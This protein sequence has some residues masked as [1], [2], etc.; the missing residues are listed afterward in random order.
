M[1]VHAIVL[2]AGKGTR[3]RSDL[4]KVL[5]LAAGRPLLGWVL[6]SVAGSSPDRTVVVVGHAAADVEAILPDDVD[7]ALQEPQRG[8][9][10]AV[11]VAL[12]HLG[13]LPADD[14]VLVG[15]GD[16][17]L[18]APDTYRRLIDEVG[19]A[20]AAVLTVDPGP[21]GFGRIV[22]SGHGA[23]AAIVEE[24]DASPDEM[25]LT[26][27]NAGIYA[28]RAG[29]LVEG[30]TRIDDRNAQGELYLT[31]VIGALSSKGIRVMGVRAHPDEVVGVN[32]HEELAAVQA[33]LR[34]R[35]NSALMASG[36]WMLDPERTYVDVGVTVAP[37]ARLH[38]GT[39]LTGLTSVDEDA[40]IGPDTYVEDSRVG[41]GARVWYSVLRG[42]VVGPEAEVGPY[43]SLRPGAV[44]E[45]RAKAGTFVEMKETVVGEGAKVPHLSYLGDASVGRGANVGAGTITCN[46]DGVDKHRTEIGEEAFIGSD[47]MLVAP[48]TI[49]A[50]AVTGAGSVITEDV[51]EGAL[52]VERSPQK[53]V[54]GYAERR[55]LRRRAR[56]ADTTDCETTD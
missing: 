36:V 25:E 14:T 15:Y 56:D 48:V 51:P 32:T 30:L 34:R 29:D 39:V 23:V 11:Q 35:I 45:R 28:F 1:S 47:T 38:P 44:L 40:E 24:R 10:H 43:A 50:R 17:P 31:D 2:A 22:R 18:I 46:Y 6:E 55:A 37:G 42:A 9:G 19:E 5:H 7:S 16:M 12:D 20:G 8:T 49:G 54:D 53:R 21:A 52:A 26:E 33:V 41:P 4:P 13:A 3:M 27:R